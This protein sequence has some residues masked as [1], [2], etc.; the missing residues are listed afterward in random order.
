MIVILLALLL[1]GLLL[2]F[3][4]IYLLELFDNKIKSKH[5]IEKLSNGKPIIGEIPQLEKEQMN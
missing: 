4:L 5:D 2:P 1:I 3:A